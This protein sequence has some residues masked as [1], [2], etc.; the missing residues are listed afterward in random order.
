MYPAVPPRRG[1]HELAIRCN[2]AKPTCDGCQVRGL[3]CTYPERSKRK[4]ANPRRGQ[5]KEPR[6]SDHVLS[7]LLERLLQVEETCTRL[8]ADAS[9]VNTALSNNS[10]GSLQGSSSQTPGQT[11]EAH[12]VV[13]SAAS[14][15]F[16][17][18]DAEEAEVSDMLSCPATPLNA[19]VHLQQ[20]FEQVLH[21]KRQNLFK[22]T[23]SMDYHIRPEIAKAC[24]ENFCTHFQIDTF[25]SFINVK[26]M[27]LIPDIIDMPEVTLE[28]AVLVL[29]YSIVY[30]GS[31]VIADDLGSQDSN[32]T[33]RVYGCCLRA[34]PAWRERSSGTKTDL[35]SAILLMRAS[36]QQCDFEFSWN[37]YKL[38]YQCVKK[39]NLHNIDQDF[40]STFM[41]Q[42][43]DDGTDHDRQGLWALVLVDLFFRLLHDKPAIMTANLTE[44]RVNLPAINV[45]PEQPEHMVPT[46]AFFVKSRLTF[47]LLRFFDLFAQG[48]D[49]KDC[50]ERIEG[51]CAEIEDLVREWSVRDSM[52]A[53]EENV[54][55]WW[56]LYDLTLTASCS[57]MIMSRKME[58]LQSEVSGIP[59]PCYDKPVSVLSV[60]IARNVLE[61]ALLGLGKYKSPLAAA[62]V[63]GAFRCYV[64]YGCL[65]RHLFVSGPGEPG[66]TSLSD[67]A[68]LEKVA[69]SMSAIAERDGDLLPLTHTLHMLN[70]SIH[71]R[72]EEKAR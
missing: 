36:F 19:D 52:D 60:R 18:N 10:P 26:L 39:L 41:Q 2:R 46:L 23:A 20:A 51:L 16:I 66:S 15:T 37:M 34:L 38:V 65:A 22:Q 50:I 21:L 31:M 45:V 64:P 25:P 53:N 27:H 4:K 57:M 1:Q 56:T 43:P 24:I 48:S 55:N 12:S 30:H 68:L 47:L 8:V 49:D 69:E 67:L 11:P 40:P 5:P 35:I 32:L 6:M 44:W 29:Y 14:R 70:I 42:S 61:L 33:Q 58:A 28:P 3:P 71:V 13:S 17:D 63:F 59:F 54:S 72:W 7:N 62:Y 9:T